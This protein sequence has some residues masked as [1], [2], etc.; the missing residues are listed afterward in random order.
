MK[1]KAYIK[2][3]DLMVLSKRDFTLSEIYQVV[4]PAPKEGLT[5]AELASRTS[6]AMGEARAELKR[7]GFV[8]VKGDLRHS[9]KVEPKRRIG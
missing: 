4:C 3:A 6:R 8:M 7:R 1:Q 2:L 5:P 9:F